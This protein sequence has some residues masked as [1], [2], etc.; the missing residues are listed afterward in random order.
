MPIDLDD[1]RSRVDDLLTRRLGEEAARWSSGGLAASAFGAVVDLVARGGKR[2][3]PSFVALG[4]AAAGGDPRSDRPVVLG[5]A[6]ELLHVSALLHDDVVDASTSRRGAPTAHVAGADR[7]RRESMVGDPDTYG[8]GLAVLAGDLAMAIA[9]AMVADAAPTTRGQWQSMK[10]EVAVGQVLD[11]A[12]TATGTRDESLALEVVRLKTSQYTV[13]RPLLIGASEASESRGAVDGD[14]A[15]ALTRFGSAVGEA[16]QLRDDILGAFGDED[17]TGKPVGA[18]LREGKPTLL[19][20]IAA[21][22]A[23]DGQR[24]VLDRVGSESLDARGV[25][26]IADLIRATGALDTVE[27]RIADL[28]AEAAR[29]LADSPVLP[30]ARDALMSFADSLMSR[31]S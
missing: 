14:L 18:D 23:D 19:L 16:F 6:V 7:H 25:A 21:A 1:V 30:A 13:V 29:V 27:R 28:T 17:I 31:V 8:R 2:V 4:W 10:T 9:D 26:E 20:A 15:M 3:R 12:A 24:R 11:H 5:A 22:R